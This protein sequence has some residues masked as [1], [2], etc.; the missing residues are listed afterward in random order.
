MSSWLI[1]ANKTINR[2]CKRM[3]MYCP[4]ATTN[5]YCQVTA[6]VH[7]AKPMPICNDE[8]AAMSYETPTVN[9]TIAGMIPIEWIRKWNID[10]YPYTALSMSE[11]IP[12]MLEDWEKEN[13]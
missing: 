2:W 5:G 3:G 12:K 11:I 9:W 7:M 13:G 4:M 8:N 10:N 6:C 1:D